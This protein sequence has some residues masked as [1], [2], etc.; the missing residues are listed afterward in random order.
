MTPPAPSSPVRKPLDKNL[1]GQTAIVTGASSGIGRAMANAL[2]ARGA[3]VVVNHPP[4]EGSDE[5][6]AA[7][8]SEIEQA[9]GR[10]TAIAA[11]I[12]KED[13]VDAMVARTVEEL[14]GLHI[15]IA[16]AGIEKP[17]PIQE[18]KLSDWQAVIAVN[19][20]GAF[21]T[22]RA[23]VREFLRHEPDPN[24]SASRG[25]IVFTS[26][27]H[28]F[29]PWAFQANYAASK[30]GIM[31]LMKSMAQELS[32]KKIRVNSVAPGAIRTPI[33]RESWEDDAEM[34]ELLELIPYGRIGEP[35]DIGRAVAWLV[36]D[37]ADYIVGTSIVID[38]GMSLY[39]GFRGGG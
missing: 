18:M 28:E 37:E 23:A 34:K 17:S 38:G 35:D 2:A 36:S 15:M 29:I 13:Q 39:P 8:V 22:A 10:A 4:F 14:G 5:K 9:G 21:L 26:S 30:G 3:N 12:S 6:A 33:N 11:D 7:V 1:S 31:L 19:L 25:K 16:N 27:V 20:T 24:L 32:D